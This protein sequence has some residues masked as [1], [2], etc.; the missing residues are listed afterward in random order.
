MFGSSG[1]NI[2]INI[3]IFR[4]RL[5]LIARGRPM[6]GSLENNILIKIYIIF[7]LRLLG[8]ERDRVISGSSGNNI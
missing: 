7:R 6:S 5:L 3:Y 2:W 4:L 8:I 1:N